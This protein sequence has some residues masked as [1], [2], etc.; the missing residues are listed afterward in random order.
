MSQ[1][2]DLGASSSSPET[3]TF[4]CKVFKPLTSAVSS[5][6]AST[7]LLSCGETQELTP[8]IWSGRTP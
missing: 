2:P 4:E 7:P 6:R 3:G 1:S 5:Q 8:E